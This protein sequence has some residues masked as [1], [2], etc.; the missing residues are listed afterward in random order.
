M[1]QVVGG[2]EPASLDEPDAQRVEVPRRRGNTGR[3]VTDRVA[4]ASQREA[5]ST[6]LWR[7]SRAD[8]NGLNAGNRA[9]L[10]NHALDPCQHIG[11]G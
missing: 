1:T 5:Q 7:Q 2:R 10:F 9:D 6:R 8:T 3:L 4:G 11:V